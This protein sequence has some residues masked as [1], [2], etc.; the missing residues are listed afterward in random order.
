MMP[1]E[2]SI[3]Q[4]LK[5]LPKPDQQQWSTT[6]TLVK[7]L[8]ATR[9]AV[10]P[11]TLFACLF[12]GIIAWPW[13]HPW[14]FGLA[15]GGVLLAHASNNLINDRV[16]YLNGLDRDNYFR[17][18]Y[19][20]QPLES[21]LMSLDQHL[22]YILVTGTMA[23]M[24]GGLIGLYLGWHALLFMGA[25]SIFVL[26]YTSPL[27]RI[28]LGEVAVWV[29]WGPLMICA[30]VYVALGRW[31]AEALWLGALYGLGPLAVILGKHT[32]KIS[33][34]SLR[35]VKTLPVLLGTRNARWSIVLVAFALPI[36]GMAWAVAKSQPA[37]L[38]VLGL[39]PM[40]IW[41]YRRLIDEETQAQ[42]ATD[43]A[44]VDSTTSPLR[45]TVIAFHFAFLAGSLLA[46]SAL[47]AKLT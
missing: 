29:V 46:M 22:R 34:D 9:A 39:L 10:Y 5:T 35:G 28:A 27:K 2:I 6:T 41:V 26:F 47:V 8:I 16:D 31:S 36:G 33:D 38:L 37:Y 15:C 43:Q 12:S 17:T 7:W 44:T 20:V 11:L 40:S 45:D 18:R 32:D 1:P 21:G 24:C 30:L 23:L 4:T 42:P 13:N 3:W 14:L 25:G 19:G